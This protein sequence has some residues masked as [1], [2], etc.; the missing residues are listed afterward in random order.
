MR[1]AWLARLN[2]AAIVPSSGQSGPTK[3]KS[4]KSEILRILN[5]P[6]PTNL[7]VSSHILKI[8]NPTNPVAS[9]QLPHADRPRS[10]WPRSQATY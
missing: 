10:A 6:N 7:V 2:D 5:I 3:S 8:P 1:L 4:H 9:T